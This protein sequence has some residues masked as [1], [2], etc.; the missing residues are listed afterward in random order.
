MKKYFCKSIRN[1]NEELFK[2]LYYNI[3][4]SSG[5]EKLTIPFIIILIFIM[6]CIIKKLILFKKF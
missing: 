2:K 6:S 3:N 5:D 1:Y 4:Y